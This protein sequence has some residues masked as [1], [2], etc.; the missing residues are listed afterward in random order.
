MI[1]NSQMLSVI[2]KV[3]N[4]YMDSDEFMRRVLL[5]LADE[6]DICYNLVSEHWYEEEGIYE[7][8]LISKES[9]RE[10]HWYVDHLF[11]VTSK[12]TNH[13]FQ[14]SFLGKTY[15]IFYHVVQKTLLESTKFKHFTYA[16]GSNGIVDF[17]DTVSGGVHNFS[18]TYDTA[19]IGM[20]QLEHITDAVIKTDELTLTDE[21]FD[22]FTK[23][24]DLV[25]SY[26]YRF[27]FV[28]NDDTEEYLQEKFD[29][30]YMLIEGMNNRKFELTLSDSSVEFVL[31]RGDCMD[32]LFEAAFMKHIK[33]LDESLGRAE[34]VANLRMFDIKDPDKQST[35]YIKED[36]DMLNTAEY[37]NYQKS[38][39]LGL[40]L[41]GCEY[42]A[43]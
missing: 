18:M 24:N 27:I 5:G 31:L 23:L 25:L 21:E 8:R 9:S 41:R 15:N 38:Y 33:K 42:Y 37:S 30:M 22:Q 26:S 7:V 1:G 11:F 3:Y 13:M 2:G 28:F 34:L 17:E 20:K 10:I 39:D 6:I 43:I 19:N 35:E 36:W 16:F 40:T 14:I 12:E 29:R 32:W 4:I